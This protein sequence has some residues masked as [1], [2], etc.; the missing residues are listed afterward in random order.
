MHKGLPVHQGLQLQ[1][2]IY[3]IC[4]SDTCT[5]SLRHS[6]LAHMSN[7]H[8]RLTPQGLGGSN[9]VPSRFARETK[10]VSVMQSVMS[11]TPWAFAFCL[12][13]VPQKTMPGALQ[14][15]LPEPIVH[16]A[17][18]VPVQCAGDQAKNESL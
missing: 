9:A 2:Q 4:F 7:A 16:T 8:Y 10:H 18:R 1:F 6:T 3:Q 13:A 17:L 11:E 15:Q 5:M 12:S 14:Q